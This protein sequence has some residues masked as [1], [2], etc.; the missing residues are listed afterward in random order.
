LY[1]AFILDKPGIHRFLGVFA[2]PEAARA[3]VKSTVPEWKRRNE[4]KTRR[5][6]GGIG[7]GSAAAGSAAAAAAA[8]AARGQAH[9]HR[10][11]GGRRI[12]IL[13]DDARNAR[14]PSLADEVADA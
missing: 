9:T 8:A 1:A 5:V 11:D 12:D 10:G 6:S 2:T 3:A 4:L 7:L 14:V 13:S